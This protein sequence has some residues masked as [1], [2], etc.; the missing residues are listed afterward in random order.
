MGTN[1][2]T[3][4]MKDQLEYT[5]NAARKIYFSGNENFHNFYDVTLSLIAWNLLSDTHIPIS[6]FKDTLFDQYS[7]SSILKTVVQNEE[8]THSIIN[9]ALHYWD[10]LLQKQQKSECE[11]LK[12]EEAITQNI[13]E[14]DWH[15]ILQLWAAFF[16][17]FPYDNQNILFELW[18]CIEKYFVIDHKSENV[19][20]VPTALISIMTQ[21]L[22][23][24]D[25]KV[26]VYDPYARTGN[27]LAGAQH[28]LTEIQEIT[29]L[30]SAR[31]SW[32]LATIRMLFTAVGSNI[33]L[34]TP[35]KDVLPNKIFDI[36]I[37]NPPYG[38]N[39]DNIK[40]PIQ[41][42][43]LVT[44]A[45]KSRRLEVIFLSHMLDRLSMDGQAAILLPYVFLTGGSTVSDLMKYMLH[46]NILDI[47]VEF[48][49]GLFEYTAI[50]PVLFCINKKRKPDEDIVIIN[51]T[52]EVSKSGRQLYLNEKT[53]SDWI[54]QT[55]DGSISDGKKVIRVTPDK[56]INGD[57]N[58]YKLLHRHE[59]EDNNE[60]IPAAE[61]LMESEKIKND[62]VAIQQE[63]AVLIQNYNN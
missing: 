7:F 29:G 20:M 36:I 32:K 28:T 4:N 24:E 15:K 16:S 18:E 34:S 54:Q 1:Y 8:G 31:L 12:L 56:V 27:L 63:I 41:D 26:S 17:T 42:K 49:Q 9:E 5:L 21:Y 33:H 47:V 11:F 13:P 55:T 52:N 46:Q 59:K 62:L 14:N 43:H 58:L 50:A 23:S 3:I 51:A 10:D 37:S 57:Y 39:R 35:D 6:I 44:I 48:P 45:K 25:K 22:K 19:H 2:K 40:I 30:S 61:L 38:D 53:L 60:R